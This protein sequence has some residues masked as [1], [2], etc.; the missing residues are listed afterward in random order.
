MH[1][2]YAYQS[3][4]LS[5]H[6]PSVTFANFIFVLAVN[7]SRDANLSGTSLFLTLHLDVP[8]TLSNSSSGGSL[9]QISSP[10]ASIGKVAMLTASS[11][12]HFPPPASL[13]AVR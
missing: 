9:S 13:S 3:N 5:P 8:S 10:R 4:L 2:Y 12:R 11:L 1:G 7:L 6:P